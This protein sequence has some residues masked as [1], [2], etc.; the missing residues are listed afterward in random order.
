M[1]VLGGQALD[2]I[3]SM[4]K[5]GDIKSQYSQPNK[6]IGNEMKKIMIMI[7]LTI[8]A[9]ADVTC[10]DFGGGMTVCTDND[11]GKQTT[12]WTY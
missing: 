4:A 11:T 8:G 7:A 9:M 6:I 12:I 5:A 1:Q 3:G 10:M 2:T